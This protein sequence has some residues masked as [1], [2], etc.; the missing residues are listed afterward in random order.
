MAKVKGSK[1]VYKRLRD[2]GVRKR[3]ARELSA[4][5]RLGA[6]GKQAPKPARLAVERLQAAVKELEGHAGRGDRKAAAR[7]A[8]RTRRKNEQR[9]STAARKAAKT[10]A[11]S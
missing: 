4:L 2:S 8:A 7:K 1:K 11:R 6:D 10:R 5:P 3:V 9:R